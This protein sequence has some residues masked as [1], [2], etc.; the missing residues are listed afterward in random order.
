[1]YKVI[2]LMAGGALGTLSRYYVSG[3][4]HKVLP[5]LFPWGTMVVNALGALVIGLLWGLFEAKNIS[6]QLRM[7]VFVG[8]L[9]GFT[10][11]STFA[12][13][14]LNLLKDNEIKMAVINVLANNILAILFVFAGFFLSKA[15][16]TSLH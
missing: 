15:I 14:T 8:F 13:E 5:G 7:F 4:S 16:L 6:P 9:G 12:L 3:L 1:M 11:F 10:T 2:F